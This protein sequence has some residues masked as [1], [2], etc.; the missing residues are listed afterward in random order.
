MEWKKYHIAIAAAI[1]II[2]TI[3]ID[4][5]SFLNSTLIIWM[6]IRA[7][8]NFLPSYRY[9]SV[10][11]MCISAAQ[12]LP[13]WMWAP[14]ELSSSY[15]HFLD[16][17]GG[18]SKE[19]V[20]KI[21]A[22]TPAACIIHEGMSCYSHP[23]WFF[24]Q[25]LRRALPMYLP[26]HLL[27]FLFSKR[28]DPKIL[29]LN[30]LRSSSFL[31]GYCTLSWIGACMSTKLLGPPTRAKLMAFVWL[32]GFSTILETQG[33]QKELAAYCLT[34]TL[35][36]LYL[37]LKNRNVIKPNNFLSSIALMSAFAT[38]MNFHIHQPEFITKFLFGIAMK[39][40]RSESNDT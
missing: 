36:S 31:S 19:I 22:G 25:G 10:I 37:A 26:I 8:R 23:F 11:I 40:K 21:R 35:D 5:S 2:P 27:S 6:L 4:S 39:S 13:T 24:I 1:S 33:R 3:L 17:Q 9:A 34:H 16:Y 18:Q 28:K 30:I 38:I 14:K 29:I 32:G 12:I 20:Q 7:I 15:I